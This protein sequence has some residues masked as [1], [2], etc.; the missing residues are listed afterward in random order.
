MRCGQHKSAKRGTA[1]KMLCSYF[2]TYSAVIFNAVFPE[3]GGRELLPNSD[4]DPE[5]QSLSRPHDASGTVVEGQG[6]VYYVRVIES[7]HVVGGAR[8]EHVPKTEMLKIEYLK[9]YFYNVCTSICMYV[10]I[11]SPLREE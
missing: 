6:V 11:S 10:S 9:T 3:V 4:S 2:I 1:Y 5:E 8:H 7:H